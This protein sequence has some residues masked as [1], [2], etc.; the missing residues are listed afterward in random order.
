MTKYS[1]GQTKVCH[2]LTYFDA[3]RRFLSFLVVLSRD[4]PR[5]VLEKSNVLHHFC[6]PKDLICHH[7]LENSCV[8]RHISSMKIQ[9]WAILGRRGWREKI[10]Q[11]CHKYIYYFE[12]TFFY[13]FMN[14]KMGKSL[15]T[16]KLHIIELV[17]YT[18]TNKLCT[19]D[20]YS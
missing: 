11:T 9:F 4:R 15:C 10:I 8:L 3:S 6:F 13:V 7:R 5:S 18:W 20:S 14:K 1:W 16:E 19:A 17:Q 2:V 12:G